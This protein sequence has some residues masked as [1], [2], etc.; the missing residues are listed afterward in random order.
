MTQIMDIGGLLLRMAWIVV[1]QA[2]FVVLG[3]LIAV[4]LYAV[5]LF[6]I[7]VD[8]DYRRSLFGSES[9][10]QKLSK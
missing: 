3:G 10:K 4:I 8:K 5:A 1:S 6:L 9:D 2:L 7:V